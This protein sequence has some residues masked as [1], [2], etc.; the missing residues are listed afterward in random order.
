MHA[1]TVSTLCEIEKKL[2]IK[3][4]NNSAGRTVLASDAAGS[5]DSRII[6]GYKQE[7][8]HFIACIKKRKQPLTNFADAAKTMELAEE[9][10]RGAL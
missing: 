10:M 8:D 2:V 5:D 7:N 1:A 9:I 6:G 4:D 3:E